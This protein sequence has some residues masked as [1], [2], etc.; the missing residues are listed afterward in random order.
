MNSISNMSSLTKEEVISLFNDLSIKLVADVKLSIESNLKAIIEKKFSVIFL[1]IDEVR[2]IGNDATAI[3][4]RCEVDIAAVRDSHVKEISA[5]TAK[6]VNLTNDH[7]NLCKNHVAVSVRA[8]I[9]EKKLEDQINRSS[10]KSL[11]F[12]GI[13]EKGRETWAD[14]KNIPSDVISAHTDVNPSDAFDM[15]ERCHPRS[16]LA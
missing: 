4:K 8:H 16:P 14:T 15:V 11:V 7:S 3:A 6:I 5:L 12:R 2:N 1:N 13:A 10:R 9:S